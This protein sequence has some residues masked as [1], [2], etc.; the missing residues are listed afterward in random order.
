MKSIDM[1]W[2]CVVALLATEPVLAASPPTACSE[3][4]RLK[5]S[6]DSGVQSGKTLVQQAWLSVEDCGR[7]DYLAGIVRDNVNLFTIPGTSTWAICRY[8]GMVD[9]VYEELDAV[10]MSCSADCCMEGEVFGTLGADVYCTLSELLDGLAEPDQFVPRPVNTCAAFSDCCVR[11]FTET[12]R[13]Q[14][15][16]YADLGA[17]G[18]VWKQSLAIQCVVQA[19]SIRH[20]QRHLTGSAGDGLLVIRNVLLRE[21]DRTRACA[22]IE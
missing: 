10:W 1:A 7:L 16:T 3:N 22:S 6:Y 11:T 17:F 4:A 5:H 8:T 19:A 21:R 13:T 12:T 14:C 15:E 20:G 18:E 2:L 9:G